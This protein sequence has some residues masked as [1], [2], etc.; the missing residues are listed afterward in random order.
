MNFVLAI[1]FDGLIYW[2]YNY[3]MI[4]RTEYKENDKKHKQEKKTIFFLEKGEKRS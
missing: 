1:Q 4:Y 2:R 3:K